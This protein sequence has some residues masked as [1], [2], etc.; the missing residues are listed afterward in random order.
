M[1]DFLLRYTCMFVPN[2]HSL[3]QGWYD[4]VKQSSV[5]Q[6]LDVVVRILDRLMTSRLTKKGSYAMTSRGVFRA[7]LK[8]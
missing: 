1:C 8:V 2:K 3:V 7:Q 5:E 4:S 6:C